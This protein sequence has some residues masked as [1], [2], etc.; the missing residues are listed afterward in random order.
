MTGELR[1]SGAQIDRL[2]SE[3]VRVHAEM[4][5][6]LDE[7]QASLD[8]LA[9]QWNGSAQRAYARAQQQWTEQ[10]QALHDELDRAR[11]NTQTSNEVFEDAARATKRLWS[12]G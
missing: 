6:A 10:M 5:G 2:V 7:L 9:Q 1:V 11:R 12:E 4:G 8:V 3:M